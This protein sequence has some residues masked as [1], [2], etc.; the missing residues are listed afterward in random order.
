MEWSDARQWAREEFGEARLGDQRRTSRLVAMAATAL[1]R[2]AGRVSGVF[3]NKAE[4]EGAYD[5]LANPG[6]DSDAVI[7]S[8]GEACTRRCRVYP[9]VFVGVDGSSV[10]VTDRAGTKDVG[11]IGTYEAGARGLKVITAY[12]VSPSG[13]PLGACAMRWWARSRRPRKRRPSYERPTRQKETQH[14][15]DAIDDTTTRLAEQAPGVRPWFQLDREG[16]GWNKLQHLERSGGFFTVRNN[17]DRRVRMPRG[18]SPL[19]KVLRRQPVLGSYSLAVPGNHGRRERLANMTTAVVTLD[20]RDK[21]TGRTWPLTLTAVWVR[22]SRTTPRGEKPIEWL[23]LT[24][25][26]V[27]SLAAA[28]LVVFGY[29]QRWRIEDFH[30]TWKS[31]V[32]DVESTQLRARSN[33]IKWATVLAAVASRAERLKHLARETPEQPASIELS[34][35]EIEATIL[36]KKRQKS[37]VEVVPD[38]MPTIAQATRWIADLG[39]YTGKSSGG[40]PG[41]ITIGRGLRDV[42]VAAEVIEALKKGRKKR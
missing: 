21:P 29:A 9:F 25:Y 34:A 28:Q 35:A 39:G 8:M 2:P 7:A 12:A 5:L 31:G 36:L 22:E 6:V 10:T 4:R 14:W 11:A 16:D 42:L 24:N 18:R 27:N 33:V 41:S 40:P 15:L 19:R 23:L 38:T 17:H 1:S 26:V 20:L 37:R 32:C 30:K 13:V 3:A